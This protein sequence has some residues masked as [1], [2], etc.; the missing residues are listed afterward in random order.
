M[1][2]VDLDTAVSGNCHKAGATG[3]FPRGNLSARPRYGPLRHRRQ[4]LQIDDIRHR[5]RKKS[6]FPSL[7]CDVDIGLA[8]HLNA[9]RNA[10][11]Q[12]TAW[13]E[14]RCDNCPALVTPQ[15]S[16]YLLVHN[17][18]KSTIYCSPYDCDTLTLHLNG[19]KYSTHMTTWSRTPTAFLRSP[20]G[21]FLI[22]RPALILPQMALQT[23]RRRHYH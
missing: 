4:P 5:S 14:T 18:H 12:D 20:R 7:S 1:S 3:D 22:I 10:V 19:P 15:A 8:A 9:Q 13:F 6:T 21:A 2:A 16:H 11:T 17:Y 23:N